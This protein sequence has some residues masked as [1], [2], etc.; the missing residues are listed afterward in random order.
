MTTKQV[1]LVLGGGGARAATQVGVIKVLAEAGIPIHRI[2]GVSAGAMIGAVYAANPDPEHLEHTTL[3]IKHRRILNITLSRA[4]KGFVTGDAFQ[5]YM[6]ELTDH[7]SFTDLSI[8]FVAVAV[9]L[10]TGQLIA[11]DQGDLP[12][13]INASCALPPVFH[14][15]KIDGR[16]LVDG[17]AVDPVPV[18]IAKRY[19]H[20]IIIAVNITQQLSEKLP[21]NMATTFM[22]Y[23]K[24]RLLA[25]SLVASEAADVCIHPYVGDTSIFDTKDKR[26]LV[27][28]GERAAREKIEI[29]KHLVGK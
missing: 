28:E 25:Q 19:S 22:R 20:D 2:V 1:T 23:Q 16:H 14:P 10:L 18:N 5:K 15:V 6:A 21:G 8:P 4:R 26:P 24:I 11:I 9:D 13:A 29:I 27:A 12:Q 17:G 3:G 7:K